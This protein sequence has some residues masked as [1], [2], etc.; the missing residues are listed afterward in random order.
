MISGTLSCSQNPPKTMRTVLYFFFF[1][2]VVSCSEERQ[3]FNR[4]EGV[5][6]TT[7]FV[8]IAP[9]TDSVLFT[10]SPT[11]QF[12]ECDLRSNRDGGQCEVTII[13]TDGITYEYR[14]RLDFA[15]GTDYITFHPQVPL[16]SDE[17]NDLTRSLTPKLIF[18]LRNDELKLLSDDSVTGGRDSIRGYHDYKVSITATK[19]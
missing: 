19:R 14:Y 2:L 16:S 12:A 1:L 7:E 17:E 5:F 4:I 6:K 9:G 13:N 15:E 10:A 18:E 3:A 11:F 8:V